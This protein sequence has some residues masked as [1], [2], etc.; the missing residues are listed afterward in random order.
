MGR[1]ERERERECVCVMGQLREVTKKQ[2]DINKGK[3]S[4]ADLSPCLLH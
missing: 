1:R 2:Q 3:I 4:Y